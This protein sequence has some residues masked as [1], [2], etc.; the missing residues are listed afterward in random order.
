MISMSFPSSEM[1][2][3]SASTHGLPMERDRQVKLVTRW[4]DSPPDEDRP[5]LE[6]NGFDSSNKPQQS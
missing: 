3:Q 5:F 1:Q 6:K 4:G 2:M